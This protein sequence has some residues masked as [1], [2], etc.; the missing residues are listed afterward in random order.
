LQAIV[1]TQTL[2]VRLG[3]PHVA[4]TSQS[5]ESTDTSPVCDVERQTMK[6][7]AAQMYAKYYASDALAKKVKTMHAVID[8]YTKTGVRYFGGGVD[9]MIFSEVTINGSAATVSARAQI[10]AKKAQDQGNGKLV[11]VTPHSQIDYT[12]TLVKVN[13]RWFIGE[14][15]WQFTPGSE[16]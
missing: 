4:I 2:P 15:T 5:I 13:E 1:A 12:F 7:H 3:T 16:P 8:H 9:W 10:W 14:E 6:D 11:Y